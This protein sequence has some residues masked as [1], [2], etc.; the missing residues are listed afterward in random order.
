MSQTQQLALTASEAVT[1]IA[2]GQLSAETY[3][4]TLL[5][6]AAALNNL[7]AFITLNTDAAISAARAVDAARAAGQ[8]L[9]RLAGLPIV[10]KD[11]INTRTLPT[12]GATP[13]MM[14]FQPNA[15]AKVLGPL[16]SA[17]AIIIGKANMHEL[18]FGI[19]TT[20]FAPFA[21]VARNPYDTNRMVG[22]SSGGTG[23]A[24]AA[25]MAPVGLGTDTGGS[26]RI[27]AALNGIAG[28]RPSVGNGGP[29]RRYDG[30]GVLPLSHTRDTVGPLGRTVADVALLDSV[31]TGAAIPAPAALAGLRFGIPATYWDVVDDQVLQV[32]NT[33][34][35][36][37]QAAGVT[38]VSVDLP[39]IRDL[40]AKVGFQLVFHEATVDI[41]AYLAD[42]GAANI[43]LSDIAANVA[44]PD[45]KA[46]FVSV[47]SDSAAAEYPDALNVYRPQMRALFDAYFSAN[48]IDAIFFPTTPLPAVP[49]DFVHGSSTV[50][51]NGGPAVD[52]FATFIR[53]CDPGSIVGIPGLTLPAGQTSG[54]LPVGMALDGP[55]G[56]DQKLL[57]IG[58][59]ME[60][61][62]GPLPAPN[63]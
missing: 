37:L 12:T 40:G 22:G 43:T 18:A 6:R 7:R 27:P 8:K 11:N 60:K 23:V 35:S 51:V 4:R 61:L 33:A 58:L 46:G 9:P 21:G 28:L 31:I 5:S 1:A 29:E 15:D 2:S 39:T 49:I 62:F 41:P 56:S 16:L 57:A 30:T 53:N 50:S 38:F 45:V 25:R 20:N 63:V 14:N 59:A 55:V 42:S 32:M 19:T 36:K 10:V 54:G 44:D 13:A 17:G 52:E 3:V 47:T 34:K 26:V 48:N 24:I